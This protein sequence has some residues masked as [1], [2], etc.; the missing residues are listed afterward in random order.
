[1]RSQSPSTLFGQLCQDKG[2]FMDSVSVIEHTPCC[3]LPMHWGGGVL[4]HKVVTTG[5][6]EKEDCEQGSKGRA[7]QQVLHGTFTH[8]TDEQAEVQRDQ[9][10]CSRSQ[11]YEVKKVSFKSTSICL[12]SQ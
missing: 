2:G 7:S 9:A 12:Q 1:M 3:M 11:S 5:L 6:S 10:I 4:L 8:L